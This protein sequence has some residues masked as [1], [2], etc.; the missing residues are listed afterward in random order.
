MNSHELR[1]RNEDAE[2][3]VRFRVLQKA[4]L[5]DLQ[6]GRARL[7]AVAQKR[8]ARKMLPKRISY[9]LAFGV[10]LVVI[11]LIV[12]MGSAMGALNPTEV[13]LTRTDT[14]RTISPIVVPANALTPG[15]SNRTTLIAPS[16]PL[17]NVVPEP[18]Q[19]PV[20][21]TTQTLAP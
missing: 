19:S 5:P 1:D 11:L 10:A 17:P 20:L 18:P 16:T 9:A 13:A 12:V 21:L 8:A 6:R 14:V 2:W 7:L 4:P 15:Q 3:R